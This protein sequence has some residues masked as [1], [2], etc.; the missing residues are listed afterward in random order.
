MS[1]NNFIFIHKIKDKKR[2]LFGRFVVTEND[3]DTGSAYHHIGDYA[4]LEEA[5]K[6]ADVY[7]QGEGYPIE[8]GISIK[9]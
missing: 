7:E 4:T 8:Y 3:A 1:A 6:A 5:A 2:K 9:I